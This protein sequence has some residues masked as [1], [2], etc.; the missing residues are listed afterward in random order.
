MRFSTLCHF[1]IEYRPEQ[2]PG[3]RKCASMRL[4]S[5]AT[6][7]VR[8]LSRYS[9]SIGRCSGRV[10]EQ[11][12]SQ[13]RNR[14]GVACALHSA[15][16]PRPIYVGTIPVDGQKCTS[17]GGGLVVLPSHNRQILISMLT[18]LFVTDWHARKFVAGT[19]P[20]APHRHKCS[21]VRLAN[22]PLRYA[23]YAHHNRGVRRRK[24]QRRLTA[25]LTT[26]TT[27]GVYT[28]S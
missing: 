12:T 7:R 15:L 2:R 24:L 28:C 10:S 27:S 8:K 23:L 17:G 14:P 9:C 19:I 16:A 6:S 13:R 22:V 3:L 11:C 20:S 4:H 5:A 18:G 21:G 25:A 1:V 26:S